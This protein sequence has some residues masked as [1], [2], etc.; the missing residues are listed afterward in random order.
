MCGHFLRPA[1]STNVRV[2]IEIPMPHETEHGVYSVHG[3][4]RQTPTP[5]PASF[6]LA[7]L[8]AKLSSP[9]SSSWSLCVQHKIE[10]NQP[11]QLM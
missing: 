6:T 2:L 10:F 8:C 9:S 3:V 5:S 11:Q 7:S 1:G 4:V